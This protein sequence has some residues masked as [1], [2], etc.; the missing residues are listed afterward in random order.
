MNAARIVLAMLF[1][2]LLVACG[3]GDASKRLNV[4]PS[5][6]PHMEEILEAVD[7]LNAMAGGGWTVREVDSEELRDDEVV[8][9]VRDVERFRVKGHVAGGITTRNDDGVLVEL[10]REPFAILIGHEL[11]HAAGLEHEDVIG[12]LMHHMIPDAGW[13]LTTEQRDELSAR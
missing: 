9:V 10:V 13:H 1:T 3:D 8:I 7:Q 6:A 11:G 5:A 2:A 12:N 4:A